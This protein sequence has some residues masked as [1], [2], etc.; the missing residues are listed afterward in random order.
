MADRPDVLMVSHT[1]WDREWYRTFEAF[2]A[3]LVDTVDRVLD[4]LGD[5]PGWKFLLDGQSIVAEDYLAV[6]PNR[7]DELERA[8]RDGR[9]A[10]GPW[11][12]QPDSLLPSGE[13]LVRNLLVGRA[14]AEAIG[15]CSRVAYV[16]DSFGHP[17]QFPQLFS[18]FGLGP[19]VYWRGNGDELDRLGPI[20]RWVAPDG[21]G[22]LAYQLGRG[23]FAAAVLPR[24]TDE[25]VD[26]ILGVLD[27]LGPIERAPALLMNGIDHMLPDDH[28]GVVVDALATRTGLR[29][30]R[31]LLDDLIDAVDPSDRAELRGELLGARTANLLPGVWSARL[32]LKLANRRAEQALLGW[33]EPWSALGRALGTPDERSSLDAAWRTLL[34]NHAHD[35]ICGCSQDEVH[36]QMHTRFSSATDLALQTTRRTVERLA[37][38]GVER[39]VPRATELDYA[40]FNPSPFPRTDVVRIPLDGFPVFF[41]SDITQDI[42]PLTVAAASVSGYTVDGVPA[43]VIRS[44]DPG[45]VRMLEDLPPLDVELV[46]DDVPAFGWKR[47][48]LTPSDPSPDDEDDGREIGADA[49]TVRADDDGTLSIGLGDRTLSGLASVEHVQ[50]HGDSY[51]FDPVPDDTGDPVVAVEIRRSRPASP[52]SDTVGARNNPTKGAKTGGRL[53]VTRWLGSGTVVR[54]EA[55]VTPGIDRVD[56]H[57]EVDHP[58]PDHRLRLLFPTGAAVDEFRAATT[59]DT[60]RRSTAPVDDTRWEHPAPRTFPHQGWIEVNGLTVAAPGLPEGEVTADGVIAV[61]VLRTFGWLARFQL[62]TRPIPAGPAL[63]TPDGEL[64]GGITADL[65]LRVDASERTLLGDELGL[66]AVPAGDAPLLDPGESLLTLEPAALV[67]STIKPVDDDT[68]L[69]RVLN[70]TDDVH[71]AVLTLARPIT[72]AESRRLDETADD[73]DVELADGRVTFTIGAH[74]LRTVALRVPAD[75]TR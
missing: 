66:L 37:G 29:V 71:T 73:G 28:T 19:M 67:L 40:V 68:V 49:V 26:G 4:L 16:P 63:P 3:R 54:V 27:R 45:R 61:T 12:V 2:R 39:R 32:D 7:R 6:R 62:G 51:D 72:R 52:R 11:Y 24:D 55:R 22:V 8:V 1:H 48:H 47:I 74:A 60:A 56:L 64:P 75:R 58:A 31:G 14:V 36:R 9:L 70:P 33:A 20:Y 44:D 10:V 50:D 38:L 25:A 23:Y 43:R 65:S 59:F 21:S 42:H 41:M 57:V 69:V 15:G 13:S 46:V 35:S 18:G 5:D 17:A 34:Q 30:E 53:R